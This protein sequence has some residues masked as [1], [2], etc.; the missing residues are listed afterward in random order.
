MEGYILI[1]NKKMVEV[2]PTDILDAVRQY[3]SERSVFDEATSISIDLS[4]LDIEAIKNIIEK[5][6]GINTKGGLKLKSSEGEGDNINTDEPKE[7]EK[8]DKDDKNSKSSKKDEKIDYKAKFAMY[9]ARLLFFSFL[10]DS[11]VKSLLEIINAINKDENNLRI[12]IHLNL[13][14]D[15]LSLFQKHINPFVLSELD[16]KI[17]NIN[18]LANDTTISPIKRASNAMKKFSRLSDSEIVTPE[19]VTDKMINSLPVNAINESNKLIDIASKQG[20]FV[21]A[22]HRKYGKEIANNFYS[23]P[24]SKIAYEFTRKV[25]SLLELNIEN[26]EKSYT[27]YDLIEENDLIEDETLKINNNIMNF[28]VIVGNPPYHQEDVGTNK[29]SASPIYNKFVEIAKE[30]KP[31]YISLIMPTKWFAGGKGLKGFRDE[32]LNDSHISELHDFLKPELIFSGL[33]NRGGI[34]YILWDRKHDNKRNL[35]KVFSYNNDLNKPD[36]FYRN[37]KTDNLSIFIRHNLA[38]KILQKIKMDSEYVSFENQISTRKPFNLEGNIVNDKNVFRSSKSG[39]KNAVKCYGKGKKVGYLEKSEINKNK[40][41]INKFKVFAPYTNNIGTE[42][43]DDNL[44]TF[45]GRPGTVC[46]ETY[47]IFGIELDLD[48]VSANNI[49]KYFE[50]KF[51]RFTHSLAKASHHGTSRTYKFVPLQDFT[52]HSDI[53]WT[54]SVEEIDQQLYKNTN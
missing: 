3:S 42:L 22:I 53:N 45:I 36:I 13:E 21:Y 11:K 2:D 20:E 15:I 24:T 29:N 52:S 18:F 34:C 28:E 19:I 9:Y 54:K 32:M 4:L 50:T 41:L 37:L 17:F 7:K 27:S 10:T 43:N 16:Y 48:K 25:Y 31:K 8:P 40:D 26:I 39:M 47:F 33:N 51:A 35:T 5:Q 44:N 46:T 6:A 14:V 49:C 23:I 30:L 1:S 12:A 38:I